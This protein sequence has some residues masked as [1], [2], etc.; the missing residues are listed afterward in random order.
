MGVEDLIVRLSLDVGATFFLEEIKLKVVKNDCLYLFL[1]FLIIRNNL[2][3]NNFWLE[4]N[5]QYDRM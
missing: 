4:C 1:G 2:W 3:K 5:Y